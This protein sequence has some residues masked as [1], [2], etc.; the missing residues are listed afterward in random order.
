MSAR[1]LIEF[2]SYNIINLCSLSVIS[3]LQN[4]EGLVCVCQ[5]STQ[6][7]TA[8]SLISPH[9]GYETKV[10]AKSWTIKLLLGIILNKPQPCYVF[11]QVVTLHYIMRLMVG[12]W[13]I[14]RLLPFLKA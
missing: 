8:T 14:E 10:D 13:N 7:G 11:R 2:A 1:G 12:V 9:E 4:R 6:K 3:I 5:T